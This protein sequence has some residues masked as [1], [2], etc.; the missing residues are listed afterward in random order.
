MENHPN[1]FKKPAV[2]S[3]QRPAW[4]SDFSRESANEMQFGDL[5]FAGALRSAV[6][7]LRSAASIAGNY[8]AS[9]L[10]PLRLRLFVLCMLLSPPT[11]PPPPPRVWLWL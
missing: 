10:R 3:L 7:S 1:T 9:L 5:F 8:A 4:K 6:C 2:C 11:T